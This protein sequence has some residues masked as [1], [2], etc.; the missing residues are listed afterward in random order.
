M[1]KLDLINH[2]CTNLKKWFSQGFSQSAVGAMVWMN[3]YNQVNVIDEIAYPASNFS[4]MGPS[5][6]IY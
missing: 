6:L 4:L 1:K 5:H 3:N 2:P